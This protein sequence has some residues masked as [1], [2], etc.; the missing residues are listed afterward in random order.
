MLISC[1]AAS[2]QIDLASPI[3]AARVGAKPNTF[4]LGE[5]PTAKHI[6]LGRVLVKDAQQQM[7]Y[8]TLLVLKNLAVEWRKKR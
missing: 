7:R 1:G 5:T 4:P 3:Y 6:W 8:Y 2:S